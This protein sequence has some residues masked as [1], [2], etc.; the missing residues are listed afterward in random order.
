MKS[1]AAGAISAAAKILGITSS[2][3]D[4]QVAAAVFASEAGSTML[5]LVPAGKHT[6]STPPLGPK[7]GD[8]IARDPSH[9]TTASFRDAGL[10]APKHPNGAPRPVQG[11]SDCCTCV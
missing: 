9:T 7:P 10:L 11:I 8:W 1:R 2:T 3:V 5:L 6:R 4:C